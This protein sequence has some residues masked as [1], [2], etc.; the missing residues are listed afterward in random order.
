MKYLITGYKTNSE[1]QEIQDLGLYCYDLRHGDDGEICTIERGVLV[2]RAGS[3]ITDEELTFENN[4][5]ITDLIDYYEFSK[6]NEEV[7][8]IEEL[9]LSKAEY[10][11]DLN[12]FS[13]C[14]GYDFLNK[15]FQDSDYPECDIVFE[16]SQRLAK[17][18]MKSENYKDMSN[19]GYEN[20]QNWIEENKE[21]IK[22]DYEQQNY[23]PKEGVK[24]LTIKQIGIDDWHRP[25]YIDRKG[26]IYKDINVGYGVILLCTASNNNFYGE[27]EVPVKVDVEINVVKEFRNKNMSKSNER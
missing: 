8:T 7:D 10:S 1:K 19:S 25:V 23:T 11:K 6:E 27:P 4:K 12:Y 2:N 24:I 5:V 26:R 13:F 17:D 21:K 20:L 9:Y 22:A 14:I 15:F 16:E 18:F 3:I